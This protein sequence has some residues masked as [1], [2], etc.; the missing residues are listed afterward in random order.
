MGTLDND[1]YRPKQLSDEECWS[2]LRRISLSGR[3]GE[4]LEEFESVGKKIA[5]KCSGLPLAANVL[6][7]LLQFK[8][9][10]QEWED[11]E[12]SEI[13]QLEN[14]DVDLF[15][16]L[17]LSYND[18]SPPLKRCFSYCAI[19]PKDHK[20]Q[21]DRLIEEWMALGYLGSV[22][23]NGEVEHKGRWYLSNLAMR[24]LFQDIEKSESGEQIEWCKMHDF[25]A[26]LRKNDN[27]DDAAKMRKESCQVC[28]P[29]LV[30]QAKE[31][32]SLFLDNR[33]H[34]GLCDCISSVRVFR[35]ETRQ[36]MEKL[37]HVR[38]L[39]LSGNKLKD[40]DL[41]IICRLYFLQTLLLS[42]CSLR[43]IPGD[44]VRLRN[45]DLSS[46]GFIDLSESICR[47]V[48]LQTL[49]IISCDKLYKLPE[50][51]HMLENLQHIFI[52][53]DRD[54]ASQGRLVQGVAQLSGLRT[55]GYLSS[56]GIEN[57]FRLAR[58][59]NK[60][61]LLK[62]LNL[63][64]AT[65]GLEIFCDTIPDVEELARTAGEAELRKKI[66]VHS[67]RII[68]LSERQWGY[69]SGQEENS[70]LSLE[71]IEALQPHQM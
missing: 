60:F 59:A 53:R 6:G 1:I 57:L 44:L 62:N 40:E 45:L 7:R 13:W 32:R 8:Y 9:N 22:S 43:N 31:Y 55:F 36:G 29:L 15:P 17:V 41:K 63:L 25:D 39:E 33:R 51:I 71:L 70:R 24:S 64:T 50:G 56:F 2:L 34:V 67:L 4:E 47:L 3:D 18:L 16:H 52:D 48:E 30:S 61:E 12:K 14:A 49:Y 5:T 69:H 27:K 46:N 26:F 19:Y 54:R 68:F 37:I 42:R 21:A 35:L 66:H 38:R 65:L 28:D 23:G 58:D 20:I 11:V 10:L